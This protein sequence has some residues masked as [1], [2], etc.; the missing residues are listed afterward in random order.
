[1][2]PIASL[3]ATVKIAM[4]FMSDSNNR[5][6]PIVNPSKFSHIPI[7]HD[8]MGVEDAIALFKNRHEP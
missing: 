4:K 6:A 2:S 5:A 8:G 7:N 3:S 1:M